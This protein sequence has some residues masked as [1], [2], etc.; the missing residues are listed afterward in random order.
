[1]RK[2]KYPD[3]GQ[4]EQNFIKIFQVELGRMQTRWTSL[5]ALYSELSA[6]PT[7]VMDFFTADFL[8][9]SVWYNNFMSIP[10]ARR[11]EINRKLEHN[12]FDYDYWSSASL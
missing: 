1:M 7:N 11:N 8:Q 10:L 3:E 4:F 5:R 6:Y 9:L 12:L 2:M